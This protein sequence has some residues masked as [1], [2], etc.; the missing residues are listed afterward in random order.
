M[1][2]FYLGIC[3]LIGGIVAFL[4]GKQYG[5]GKG[6]VAGSN[7]Y[8]SYILRETEQTLR[9]LEKRA[10]ERILDEEV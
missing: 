1:E 10:N 3:Y 7:A 9:D 2:Y 4:L 6:F 8:R 5:F